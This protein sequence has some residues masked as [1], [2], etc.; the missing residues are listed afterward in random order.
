MAA[1]FSTGLRDTM[2]GTGSFKATMDNSFMKIYAG[3]VP[4]TAD[5]A[6][7]AATLLCTL[8]DNGGVDGLDF[9]AAAVSGVLSKASA[10]TWKGTN[11][12]TGAATFYRLI[13]SADDGSSSTT[14][15]RIQGTVGAISADLLMANT[16]LT[17]SEEFTLSN[18]YVELPT[19]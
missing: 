5:D 7:G 9:E 3:A 10:Q 14:Y 11:V 12:A 2:L 6:I 8:S 15:A 17:V 13:T 4:A 19:N 18:Y 1:K 16:T